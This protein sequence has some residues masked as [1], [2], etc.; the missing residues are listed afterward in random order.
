MPGSAP[1]GRRVGRGTG[2]GRRTCGP[3]S[4]W[5][6]SSS[7]IGGTTGATNPG[8]P[9]CT[10]CTR[11]TSWRRS[12]SSA[13]LMDHTTGSGRYSSWFLRIRKHASFQWSPRLDHSWRVNLV[14]APRGSD[15]TGVCD[16]YHVGGN[17]SGAA[18]GAGPPRKARPPSGTDSGTG[19][20]AVAPG[21]TSAAAGSPAKAV[22]PRP[23]SNPV[24]LPACVGSAGLATA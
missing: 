8:R 16:G 10:A 22:P 12:G 24:E 19:G 14:H 3:S 9:R 20:P 18:V 15:R 11:T 21:N 17:D 4:R 1:P 13:E 5:V 6:G 7:W 23:K 2:A